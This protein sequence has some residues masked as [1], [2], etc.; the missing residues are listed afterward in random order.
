MTDMVK[1]QGK[2]KSREQ[3]RALHENFSKK[4]AA[5]GLTLKEIEEAARKARVD[6]REARRSG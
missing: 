5:S 2:A 4:V 1:K 3:M 6:V